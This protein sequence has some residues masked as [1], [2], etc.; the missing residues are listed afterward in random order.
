[1][2]AAL[3]DKCYQILIIFLKSIWEIPLAAVCGATERLGGVPNFVLRPLG[4]GEEGLS[5]KVVDSL[6]S[7]LLW[8]WCYTCMKIKRQISNIRTQHPELFLSLRCTR[9]MGPVPMKTV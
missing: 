9:H 6:V 7:E 1:M 8:S 4:L 2:P 5:G 3:D